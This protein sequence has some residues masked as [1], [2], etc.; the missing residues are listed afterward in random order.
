MEGMVEENG[1]VDPLAPSPDPPVPI[2]SSVGVTN[3]Q[4]HLVTATNIVQLT[5]P[6]HTQAQV[7]GFDPSVH[8]H[9]MSVC[10][11]CNMRFLYITSKIK[12][13]SG[14]PSKEKFN[15]N[16]FLYN[17]CIKCLMALIVY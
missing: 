10:Q 14:D 16:F 9:C 13:F 3:S 1:T 7:G 12:Q 17:F 15:S 8:V 2:A 11:H 5:L 4:P 6:S